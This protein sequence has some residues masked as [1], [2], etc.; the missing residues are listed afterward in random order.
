MKI[1]IGT[2]LLFSINVLADMSVDSAWKRVEGESSTLAA[3]KSDVSRAKL[4]VSS[5]KSMYLPAISVEAS[6]THLSD[7]ISADSSD[8]SNFMASL[9]N[10]IPFP[11][12]M[13]VSEKD[14]F[15][16]DLQLLWPLYVGG[17]IDATREIYKSK[18]LESQALY[19]MQKDKVFL[20]F[21]KTYYGVVMS[22]SLYETRVE[23][24][25]A[26]QK[27]FE[28]AKKL[29][30]Q[31]QIARVELL[32]A[33]VKLDEA[34]IETTKAKH[35]YDISLSALKI[36]I[37]SSELPASNFF[38]YEDIKDEEFYKKSNQEN[39]SAFTILDEKASQG[40]SL[41]KIKKAAWY[42]KV[43]AFGDYNLYKD[44]SPLMKMVPEWFGG[45]TFQ[46][47]L[48]NRS[49]RAQEVQS[50]KL[51][52]SKAESLKKEAQ[53]N[54]LLL[55]EKTY[56]EMLLY[57]DEYNSL[58]S[59]IQLSKEN[60][61]LRTIA[62]REGLSTSLDVIDAQMLLA[63]AKT[64]RLNAAYNYVQKISQLSVLSGD[65]NNF[66]KIAGASEEIE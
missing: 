28:N 4:K 17:K 40:E 53:E 31:G 50:A 23:V 16:A 54:L 19:E 32:H 12:K 22:R 27:H 9:P 14:I 25:K 10:P 47:T 58:N 11:S 63:G 8:I 46:F 66:F 52:K 65:M 42:P 62:F 41:V 38:V 34:K 5:S 21:I 39:Y 15:L 43:F 44:D 60:Y 37:K 35:Q 56:N 24:Q 7:V 59:S 61:K 57:R 33:E 2:L 29:K 3:S 45:L 64:K 1:V 26:L 13:D 30:E 51:L 20:K 18:M 48:L 49:D 6:Y 36:M 55:V